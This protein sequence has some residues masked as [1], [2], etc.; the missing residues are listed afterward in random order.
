MP[1]VHTFESS[2]EAYDWSQCRDD[3]DIGDVLYVPS[4]QVAAV[5]VDAWPTVDTQDEL[6]EGCAFHTF[7]PGYTG[8]TLDNGKYKESFELAAATVAAAASA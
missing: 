5:L 6:P 3:I 8:S 2:G 4:E 7:S 1:K